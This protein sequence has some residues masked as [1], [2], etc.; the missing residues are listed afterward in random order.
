MYTNTPICYEPKR[1]G[2][3]CSESYRLR[4]NVTCANK[5]TY[6]SSDD[7]LVGQIETATGTETVDK[8]HHG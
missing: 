4:F 2:H 3:D 8:S 5:V 1:G 7:D 6:G